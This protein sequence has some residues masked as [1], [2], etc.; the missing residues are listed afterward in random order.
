MKTILTIILIT[1]WFVVGVVSLIDWIIRITEKRKLYNMPQIEK[2]IYLQ[3]KYGKHWH[4]YID[5]IP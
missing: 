1:V 5:E 3:K 4:N 2:F